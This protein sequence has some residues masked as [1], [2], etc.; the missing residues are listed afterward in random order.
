M[1]FLRTVFLGAVAIVPLSCSD[2]TPTNVLHTPT[3]LTWETEYP[4]SSRAI[5][6]MWALDGLAVAVG[7]DG[8]I[9]RYNGSAWSVQSSPVSDAL[10]AV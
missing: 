3:P 1:R 5:S 2:N 4:L 8:L 6:A 10:N 9:L 7:A